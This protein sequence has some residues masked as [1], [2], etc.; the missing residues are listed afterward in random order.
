MKTQS[1]RSPT[2]PG[3]GLRRFLYG[4][5][6]LTGG[7]IMIVEVLGA[8]LLAPYFGTSTFVWTAQITMALLALAMGYAAGGW[9]ADRSPRLRWIYGG[10]LLAAIWLAVAAWGVEPLAFAFLRVNLALGSLLAS[11][12]LFLIPLATL[13]MV[14]PFFVKVITGDLSVVG[15]NVGRLTALSTLGS[16]LGTLLVGYVLIP[17]VPNT[18]TLVLVAAALAA[19][20]VVFFA[21]WERRLLLGAAGAALVTI[22]IGLV[23]LASPPLRLEDSLRELARRNSPFGLMQVVEDA[24]GHH[25]L[26]LN[27]LLVQNSYDP[28]DGRSSSLFTYMLH[29]LTRSYHPGARDILCIGL[30]V[31]IVPRQFAAEGARVDVVEI[32]RA[33]V[34]LAQEY[35]DFDPSAVNLILADGRY[36][37]DTTTNRYDAVVLDAF[38]GE[39]PPSHL[40]TREAF[41]AMRRCLR[42]GGV[43]V[44]NAFGE[45][46][47]GRD[48]QIGSLRKTLGAVFRSVRIH[49]SGNGNVF[50]VAS[51]REP[52]SPERPMDFAQVPPHLLGQARSAFAGAPPL[53]PEAGMVLTD[54]FNPV[55]FY[56]A[57]N[58]EELRRQLALSVRRL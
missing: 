32:N 5:A 58:R 7:A 8:K 46:A 49:A 31:G 54:D 13:A 55:E 24:S 33:V 57:R 41:A 28:I 39:S 45:F 44:M 11:L 3:P 50:F 52:L 21:V 56:D 10:I 4:T 30:G 25:R 16:V 42:P 34:P 26:Y 27:D 9:L 29:G 12:T 36:V 17:N 40:M 43:L 37:V 38:L 51:D 53:R 18:M 20:A 23:A 14:G 1:E 35:F 48:F 22:G 6:M 19:V 2:P 47:P 15:G